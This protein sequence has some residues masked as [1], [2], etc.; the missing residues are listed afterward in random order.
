MNHNI[1]SRQ[2][3]PNDCALIEDS[4]SSLCA[5]WVAKDPMFLYADSEDADQTEQMPRLICVFAG[6]TCHFVGV[7]VRRLNLLMK[8]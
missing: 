4:E 8:P 6:R 3:Q 2:N 1:N 7:V 5:Q